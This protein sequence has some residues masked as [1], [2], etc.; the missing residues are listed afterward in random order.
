[1]RCHLK[2]SV[3]VGRKISVTRWLAKLF[4]R[5]DFTVPCKSRVDEGWRGTEQWNRKLEKRNFTRKQGRR[6]V[7]FGKTTRRLFEPANWLHLDDRV[8]CHFRRHKLAD[9]INFSRGGC[10]CYADLYWAHSGVT[11]YVASWYM[12][13]RMEKKCILFKML[14]QIEFQIL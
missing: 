2:R 14:N 11:Q 13:M 1:M 10:K 3:D 6:S 9:T 5:K 7:R 4:P 12:Y 8:R